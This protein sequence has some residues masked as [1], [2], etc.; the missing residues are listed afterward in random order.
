MSALL[1]FHDPLAPFENLFCAIFCG[2][3]FDA[4][5]RAKVCVVPEGNITYSCLIVYLRI[6]LGL[7]EEGENI[8]NEMCM[9]FILSLYIGLFSNNLSINLFYKLLQLNI[10]YLLKI[11]SGNNMPITIIPIIELHYIII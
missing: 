10:L 8:F 7:V 9:C 1:S 11:I 2:G 6:N 5:R 4:F 3:I